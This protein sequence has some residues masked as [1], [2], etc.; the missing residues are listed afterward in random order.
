LLVPPQA[1]IRPFFGDSEA[2]EVRNFYR[3]RIETL[4]PFVGSV[5]DA[6]ATDP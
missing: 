5:T 2:A 4:R 3:P 6:G 1:A